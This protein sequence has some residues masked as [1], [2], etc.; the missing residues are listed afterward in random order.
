MVKLENGD[1][2]EQSKPSYEFSCCIEILQIAETTTSASEET[3]TTSTSTAEDARRRRRRNQIRS[4]NEL[5]TKVSILLCLVVIIPI[6]VCIVA[7]VWNSPFVIFLGIFI[8]GCCAI[9]NSSSWQKEE[10]RK[11]GYVCAWSPRKEAR[12]YTGAHKCHQPRLPY[13]P[14]H[15]QEPTITPVEIKITTTSKKIKSCY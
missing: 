6:S 8:I 3:P 7:W 9:C 1:N 10:R 12:D 11:K 2:I 13:Q 15:P 14:S 5:I 4:E